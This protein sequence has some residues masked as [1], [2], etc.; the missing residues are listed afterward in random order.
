MQSKTIDVTPTS[1]TITRNL[2]VHVTAR[3]SPEHGWR[4]QL[5]SEPFACCSRFSTLKLTEVRHISSSIL[6]FELT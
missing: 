2:H 1:V 6:F 5:S 3:V 4:L